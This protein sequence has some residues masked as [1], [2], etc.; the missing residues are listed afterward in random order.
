MKD[1][2]GTIRNFSLVENNGSF[3]P[4]LEMIFVVAELNYKLAVG[5]IE[6]ESKPETIRIN[7]THSGLKSLIQYLKKCD[8]E[9][10][11]IEKFQVTK[12]VDAE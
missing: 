7:T 5:A 3:V 2:C 8:E 10:D 6:R 11:I 4:T 1:L 9:F 12:K